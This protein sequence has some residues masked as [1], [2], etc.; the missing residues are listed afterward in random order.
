MTTLIHLLGSP[1]PHHNLT[2]L[3]YFNDVLSEVQPVAAPR[4]FMVVSD[5]TAAMATFS[6]LRVEC[7]ASK[8]QLAQAVIARGAD[9]QQRFFCH[10]QFNALLWLALLRG[11]LKPH[12]LY[13][14]VWGADL[15]ED[16]RS[17]KFRLFYLLRRRAQGRIAHLFAT[18]GDIE[19]YQQRHRDVPTSLLYFPTRMTATVPPVQPAEPF[20]VLL[21]NS[22]DPSNRHREALVA[23]RQQFDDRVK[24][25]VPLGYPANNERYIDDVRQVANRLF[26]AG[27]VELLTEKLEF[28][29]YLQLIARCQLGWFSFKRQQGIGT[30]CLLIQANIPFV[31][32]RENPF[33]RD[34]QEQRV[35]VLFSE[36]PLDRDAIANARQQL[37][38]LDKCSVDFLDPAYLHGWQQ[39]LALAEGEGQ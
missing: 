17:L 27:N 24:I 7:F 6:A 31:L 21:G 35:P 25:M 22:G 38:Q 3:R 2:I 29:A 30:L 10:G 32:A 14:H 28:S 18:R 20:T 37:V 34:L 33:W 13:W 4:H 15:Y 8:K 11:A 23:L 12:Q 16:S 19:H 36:E 1:V 5:D 39:A 9:R 26:P